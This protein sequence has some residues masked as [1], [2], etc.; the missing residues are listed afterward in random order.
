MLPHSVIIVF[1]ILGQRFPFH[2][3]VEA[4]E[5]L[6]DGAKSSFATKFDRNKRVVVSQVCFVVCHF[7][8]VA[9]MQISNTSRVQFV[10]I[11]I[12][13]FDWLPRLSSLE[14]LWNMWHNIEN[15]NV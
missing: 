5:P 7:V 4:H 2:I 3:E 1:G 6:V 12:Y 15:S 11:V 8:Q 14:V 9:W 13:L 10:F